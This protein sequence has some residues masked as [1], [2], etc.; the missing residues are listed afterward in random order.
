[1]SIGGVESRHATALALVLDP[2]A[3]RRRARA[4]TDAGPEGRV[5]DE[6]VLTDEEL[7]RREPVPARPAKLEG[8]VESAG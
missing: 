1:M 8:T 7:E 5:P 6:A 2:T 4:F 3:K